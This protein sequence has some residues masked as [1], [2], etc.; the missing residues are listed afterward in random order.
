[1]IDPKLKQSVWRSLVQSRLKGDN[2]PDQAKY[3]AAAGRIL[4]AFPAR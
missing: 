2:D 4:A 1:M 3:N